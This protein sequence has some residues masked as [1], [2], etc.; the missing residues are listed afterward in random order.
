[1][2]PQQQ[3]RES[4]R[5]RQDLARA[6]RCAGRAARILEQLDEYD[7]T[8]GHNVVASTARHIRKLDDATA[9]ALRWLQK[10]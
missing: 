3:H 7:P 2:T 1:M 6:K 9:R 10:I 5:L 8:A 4:Q